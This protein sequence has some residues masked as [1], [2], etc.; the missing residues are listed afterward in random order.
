MTAVL[1]I[2]K[3]NGCRTKKP[4]QNVV[5]STLLLTLIH[6]SAWESNSANFALSS[7]L[8]GSGPGGIG[9]PRYPFSRGR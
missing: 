2:G 7:S 1:I 6:P 4:D 9:P 5:A 8:R 3:L